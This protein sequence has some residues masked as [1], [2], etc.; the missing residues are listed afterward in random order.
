M[1]HEIEVTKQRT[2]II[3]NCPLHYL[4][5]LHVTTPSNVV[6][7]KKPPIVVRFIEGETYAEAV[8][9]NLMKDTKLLIK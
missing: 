9:Q 6:Y 7:G 8:A 5:C 1:F 2:N 4:S 3:N